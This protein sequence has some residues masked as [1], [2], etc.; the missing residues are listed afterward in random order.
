[1]LYLFRK[2]LE[3]YIIVY[4]LNIF[5]RIVTSRITVMLLLVCQNYQIRIAKS[6]PLFHGYKINIYSTIWWPESLAMFSKMYRNIFIGLNTPT[7]GQL[8]VRSF[9]MC[10]KIVIWHLPIS[11]HNFINLCSEEFCKSNNRSYLII[12]CFEN[13]TKCLSLV[14]VINNTKMISKK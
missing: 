11:L 4:L 14:R 10:T 3:Q 7:I 9:D 1:M 12:F 5:S 2:F 13:F 6:S 8:P